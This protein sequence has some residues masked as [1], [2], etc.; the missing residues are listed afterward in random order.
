MQHCCGESASALL[1]PLRPRCQRAAQLHRCVGCRIVS[2]LSQSPPPADDTADSFKVKLQRSLLGSMRQTL[3]NMQQSIGNMRQTVPHRCAGTFIQAGG[4]FCDAF[5]EY[6]E[7]SPTCALRAGTHARIIHYPIAA[8]TISAL[9]HGTR[10][11]ARS[12]ARTQ[13]PM[14]SRE[15]RRA[16]PA[17][18]QGG[19]CRRAERVAGGSAGECRCW[20]LYPRCGVRTR[21]CG[22]RPRTR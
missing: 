9:A 2:V 15:L 22:R 18:R 4:S 5:A 10:S 17:G 11:R 16:A 20:V 19:D 8:C 21:P 13:V 6:H 3:C 14:L 12:C 1:Q 7:Q